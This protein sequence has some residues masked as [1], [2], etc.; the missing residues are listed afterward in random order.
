VART[1]AAAPGLLPGALVSVART[2]A[3]APPGLLPAP[4]VSADRAPAP[5]TAAPL[6][7]P[8]LAAAREP[9]VTAV[10]DPAT[11]QPARFPRG[12]S[13]QNVRL[14]GAGFTGATAVA[15]NLAASPDTHI[16][17]NSFTVDSAMQLTATISI[18]SGAAT[19]FR[20][21]RVTAAGL[22]STAEG[23]GGNLLEVSP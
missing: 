2:P 5:V 7:G 3:P 6:G 12:T 15:F 21:T 13:N 23:T 18:A 14:L 19:G 17:V 22:T 9:V 20:V 10:Q 11:G 1:P 8:L 16:T 4:L